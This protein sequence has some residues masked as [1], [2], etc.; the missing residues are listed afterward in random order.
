MAQPQLF[1]GTWEE[2]SQH[3]E[4]FI[5]IK[6]LLLIVPAVEESGDRNGARGQTLAE[7]LT[8]LLEEARQIQPE[9][10]TALSNPDEQAVSDIIADKYRKMG[11][12][13]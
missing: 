6:N 1:Q 4:R 11:F 10:P 13:V 3:A 7:A 12:K 5:G 8:D 9:T 2:L